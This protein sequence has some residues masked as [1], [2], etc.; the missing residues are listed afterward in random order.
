MLI[1][2]GLS[3]LVVIVA[4]LAFMLLGEPSSLAAT[5]LVF[6][7]A[8]LPLVFAAIAHFVPVLTRSAGAPRGIWLAPLLL[9]MSGVLVCLHFYGAV[10]TSM[11]NLAAVVCRRRAVA[12]RC[13]HR[14][15]PQAPPSVQTLGMA[16]D[17]A[18]H[19]HKR[20]PSGRRTA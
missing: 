4:A 19:P 6:A 8:V 10:G 1:Y 2:L 17:D 18:P 7:L 3:A 14:S 15:P 11:L 9:Q 13:W 5:H 12:S 20:F 16:A